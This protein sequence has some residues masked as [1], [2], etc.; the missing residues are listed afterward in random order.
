MSPPRNPAVS[1]R[2]S[3]RNRKRSTKR[4]T[5]MREMTTN[6]KVAEGFLSFSGIIVLRHSYADRGNTGAVRIALTDRGEKSP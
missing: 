1:S 6:G 5:G 2:G 3:G 4:L